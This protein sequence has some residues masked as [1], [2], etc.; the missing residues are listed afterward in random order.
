MTDDSLNH[1]EPKQ[2]IGSVPLDPN[3]SASITAWKKE[4]SIAQ[5]KYDMEQASGAHTAQMAK[6]GL[7][8]DLMSV[9]GK[10]RPAKVK[11]RSAVQP[12]LIRRQAEWR[13]SALT[14]PFLGTSKL[15][16][17]NPLT[18][19]DARSAKQNELLLNYQFR[20][21]LN[22]VNFI[23]DFVRATVDEGTCVLRVGWQRKTVMTKEMAP[24]YSYFPVQSQEQV[25]ALQQGMELMHSDPRMYEEQAD[26]ALKASL[27]YYHE[28]GQ[29]VMAQQTG[30][31]EVEVEKVLLNHPTVEVMNPDN[32]VIDPSC[33][34]DLAK[35]KFAV[36]SF[37]TCKAD[38]EVEKDRYTNLDKVMW[39]NAAPVSDGEFATKT[40]ANFQFQDTPRKKIIAYEYWGFYDIHGKGELTSIVATW[41]GNT[42]IRMEENPY[43]DK[44]LPF[45]IAKYL[46]VKRE[47]YGEPDAE[48]LEDNQAILGAVTRGMI[49]LLGRSANGQQGFAKG[50]LDPLNR[51]RYE[52]GQDYEFNP[53]VTPQA[54]LIEHKYPELPQSALL[55]LN[56]Q[57]Q[58]AEALTGVKSFG[59]GISGE[60]YGDVAA[61][62]RGVLDASSKREMAILRRLAKAIAD[63]GYKIIKMNAVFLSER[64][65]VRVTNSEFVEI[66]RDDLA[67]DF[68]LEVDISTA[69]VDDAKAKDLSFM[70][71]TIGPNAGQ[72][73]M[74]TVLSEIADL[75]RMP[76]L[77]Q[78][79]RT[80]KPEPSP[81]QQELAKLEV[82]LK[83]AEVAKINSEAALN[84]AKAAEAMAKKDAIDLDYVEQ[85][86]G[87]KHARAME[88]QKAQAE[89]NQNLQ[90]TKA[91]TTARKEG[92]Q[93]P[94]LAAAIGF[95]QVSDK[96]NDAPRQDSSFLGSNPINTL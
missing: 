65:V 74:L 26:P 28:T 56:L 60:A 21:K 78:Q 64:E 20:T 69:E 34:G 88:Q 31:Q 8:N 3:Q 80:Y 75:K 5:L 2:T 52:N 82:E 14:E 71:Q 30:E 22:R 50:M 46:P 76:A 12:K 42:M 19:E 73:L 17:I 59:G 58:E 81:E 39:E 45:V 51:R 40:P 90:I 70:L 77:A 47:L 79:L 87:T 15:Y 13:Y 86:T 54:G 96:L 57:N 61:G 53:T 29:T 32:V 23:D 27:D 89:G 84:Q 68:D 18:F 41:V 9:K 93:A 35:A 4:P 38:L 33:G 36:V 7:W 49:D 85:D 1:T 66:M 11:G 72:E 55:M 67:G 24:V 63:V 83:R 16:K 95:N 43:P 94:D 62:I 6:I 91:L 44:K 25:Q 48:L 10:A 37:E 92:E